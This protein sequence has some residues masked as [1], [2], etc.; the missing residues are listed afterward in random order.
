VTLDLF[1]PPEH[2]RHLERCV[3][4]RRAQPKATLQELADGL[5]IGKMTVYRALAYARRMT[6][7]GLTDPYRE[8]R[9]RPAQVSRWK[10]RDTQPIVTGDS[11]NSHPKEDTDTGPATS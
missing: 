7:A 4:A 11:D 5:N 8:V 1:T 6:E 3:A 9:E 2:V 10:K